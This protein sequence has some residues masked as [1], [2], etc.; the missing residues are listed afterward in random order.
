[1]LVCWNCGKGLEDVPQPISRQA[2]CGTCFHELHCCRLCIHFRTDVH[3]SCEEDRADPPV[4]KDTANFCDWFAPRPDAYATGADTAGDTA[5]AKLD[6]LFGGNAA[7]SGGAPA[8]DSASADEPAPSPEA[9][10]KARLDAL[11]RKPD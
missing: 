4:N 5:R 8:D 1:M 7:T 11:F 6:A 9:D 3:S 2:T 10:A